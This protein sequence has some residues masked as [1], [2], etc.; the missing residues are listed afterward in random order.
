MNTNSINLKEQCQ[1]YGAK[2]TAQRQAILDTILEHPDSHLSSEDIYAILKQKYPEMGLAT[3]YRT[4][5][6][7][8]K[9]E[10]VRRTDLG[11]GCVRY[12]IYNNEAHAHHHLICSRCG[13]VVDMED[14]L[15]E[16][17]EKQ[18][19]QKNHFIVENHSLKFYGR[20][21]KCS[22]YKM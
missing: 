5:L 22:P 9:M 10:L 6:L 17:L 12:E 20:C 21:E 1:Q 8:E 11:E 3:V 18:I 4:L 13:S 7:L 2:Y 15:L 19:Y 14:D 16:E